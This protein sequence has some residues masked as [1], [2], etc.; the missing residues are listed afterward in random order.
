MKRWMGATI[1]ALLLVVEQ[2][3]AYSNRFDEAENRWVCDPTPNLILTNHICMQEPAVNAEI[4]GSPVVVKTGTVVILTCEF[5]PTNGIAIL[6]EKDDCP[7]SPW[8]VKATNYPS[9]SVSSQTWSMAAGIA[10][11]NGLGDEATTSIPVS[12]ATA[13]IA[14]FTAYLDTNG[15]F[16]C[17]FGSVISTSATVYVTAATASGP[18][19]LG[20]NRK[21][22]TP[23][24]TTGTFTVGV[25]PAIPINV[26]TAELSGVV[27]GGHAEM[28]EPSSTTGTTLQV[29]NSVVRQG[30]PTIG[31]CSF[32]VRVAPG[33]AEMTQN[34]TV[35]SLDMNAGKDEDEEESEGIFMAYNGDDDN[36]NGT[37][38]LSDI[39]PVAGENDLVALTVLV[40]PTGGL[41][42][43]DTGVVA[44][45]DDVQKQ[46]PTTNFTMNTASRTFYMEGVTPGVATLGG[47][48]FIPSIG[49]GAE[50]A[51]KVGVV[52]VNHIQASSSV[53][54][55]SAQLFTGHKTD[56]GDPCDKDDPGQALVVFFEDVRNED[57][58]ANDFSVQLAANIVPSWVGA[59]ALD[60][61]WRKVGGPA[62]GT[63]SATNSFDVQYSNPKKGGLYV[64]EFEEG[65]PGDS[66]SGV[67]IL[68]PLGGPDVTTYFLSECQRYDNWLA[69]MKARVTS[70]ISDDFARGFTIMAFFTKTVANM[71]HKFETFE[72]G[73]S[74][75]KR[76]CDNTVTISDYVFGKDHLGNFLFSYLA[77]R[78]GF[79]FGTTQFGAKLVA[80]LTTKVP[81]NPDDQAAYTAGFAFGG[82]PSSD[83]KDILESKDI[84]AMQNEL[85]RHGW[86]SSDI[87]SGSAY[88]T[89]GATHPGLE[90]P[91]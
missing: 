62:S 37:P 61:V 45:Y 39:G 66:A 50:D 75:C 28:V 54:D 32:T 69:A 60:E 64:I 12:N 17:V 42:S 1:L 53:A 24:T 84:H 15:V 13:A 23:R 5:T 25:S 3:Y 46:H 86:P 59:A 56:F 83:F 31:H 82:S 44:Y 33:N 16:P 4:T 65:A 20:I 76:F 77:A 48:Y 34:F 78:T 7:A 19:A 51:V 47:S 91:D 79:N 55:N 43:L 41:V 88:P 90:N 29:K 27:L 38:D 68:L 9:V 49:G 87:D 57:N 21:G 67:N 63:L 52:R 80:K 89:W 18:P 40:A 36:N 2:G 74:P 10:S 6:Q 73:D 11:S 81:D 8:E 71:N 72:V 85:A 70:S 14:T 22:L 26:A 30:C 58:K 35:V